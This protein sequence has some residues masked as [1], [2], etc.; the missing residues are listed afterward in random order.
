VSLKPQWMLCALML[1]GSCGSDVAPP[2]VGRAIRVRVVD[3][4]TGRPLPSIPVVC[5]VQAMVR[6]DIPWW[7]PQLGGPAGPRLVF[8]SRGS[9]DREGW[10]TFLP[11]PKR[12]GERLDQ[13]VV[14]ANVEVDMQGERARSLSEAIAAHCK[15]GP[16]MCSEAPLEIQVAMHLLSGGAAELDDLLGEPIAQYR[17]EGL[18]LFLDPP[19]AERPIREEWR[20]RIHVQYRQ[21]ESADALEMRLRSAGS[22]AGGRKRWMPVTPA[23]E[24]SRERTRAP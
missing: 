20:E 2:R 10:V 23:T 1:L 9:T 15:D 6:A 22:S 14:L 13:V 7:A 18:V 8:G 19:G 24:R 17:G 3:E 5:A 16:S 4:L 21:F 11:L 12:A